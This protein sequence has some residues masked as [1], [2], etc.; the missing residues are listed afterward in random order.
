MTTGTILILLVFLFFI[1][2][3]WYHNAK[4]KQLNDHGHS[5]VS[6]DMIVEFLKVEKKLIKQSKRNIKK[7]NNTIKQY[8]F[9]Q[10]EVKKLSKD[11]YEIIQSIVRIFDYYIV[12]QKYIIEDIINID[13]QVEH[14]DNLITKFFF[15]NNRMLKIIYDKHTS[16][17]EM[18]NSTNQVVIKFNLKNSSK[19]ESLLHSVIEY[20]RDDLLLLDVSYL[21]IYREYFIENQALKNQYIEIEK[22]L[23]LKQRFKLN[24]VVQYEKKTF[25]EFLKDLF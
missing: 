22:I 6:E 14:D 16:M 8:E 24:T 20:E 2:Y 23:L 9:L 4:Y 18:L 11:I 12:N 3:I 5:N 25:K 21:D 10:Q 15:I 1:L 19:K 7:Y 17:Y 13:V